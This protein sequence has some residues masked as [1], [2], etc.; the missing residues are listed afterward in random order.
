MALIKFGNFEH[1]FEKNIQKLLLEIKTACL[2]FIILG[3]L[4]RLQESDQADLKKQNYE[5]IR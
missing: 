2:I 3:I 5:M 1:H 4:A